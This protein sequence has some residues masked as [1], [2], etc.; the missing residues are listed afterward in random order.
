MT[1]SSEFHESTSSKGEQELV[2]KATKRD[3]VS[4]IQ[5][6]ARAG[7]RHENGFSNELTSADGTQDIYLSEYAPGSRFTATG[8]EEVARF[9]VSAPPTEL[10][11]E[12]HDTTYS[13]FHTPDGLGMSKYIMGPGF[14]DDE[15]PVDRTPLVIGEDSLSIEALM[16]SSEKMADIKREEAKLGLDQVP[17]DEAQMLLGL[18]ATA[19]PM[20]YQD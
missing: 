20:L 11:S 13:L 8:H 1:S 3:L 19:G 16:N 18:I 4:L 5:A 15:K 6:R 14:P 2:S 12:E 17:E 9:T 7:S 10:P